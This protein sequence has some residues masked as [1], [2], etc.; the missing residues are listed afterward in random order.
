MILFNLDSL[1]ENRPEVQCQG[2]DKGGIPE[3]PDSYVEAL[4]QRVNRG[5]FRFE[6]GDSSNGPSLVRPQSDLNGLATANLEENPLDSTQ[7]ISSGPNEGKLDPFEL[8][9]LGPGPSLSDTNL[10]PYILTS[11]LWCNESGENLVGDTSRPSSR[12]RLQKEIGKSGRNIKHKLL[13][14]FFVKEGIHFQ[15]ESGSELKTSSDV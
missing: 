5:R 4:V 15:D 8:L 11:S 10:P 2:W 12:K 6:L 9:T 13:C 3:S 7:L 1:N 14:G